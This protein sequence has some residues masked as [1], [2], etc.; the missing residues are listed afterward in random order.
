MEAVWNG[1]GGMI[2]VSGGESSFRG[3]DCGGM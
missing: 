1:N 2:G 3:Q